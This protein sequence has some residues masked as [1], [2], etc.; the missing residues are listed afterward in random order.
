MLAP[1]PMPCQI[2]RLLEAP[3][4]MMVAATC[5]TPSLPTIGSFC[6]PSNSTGTLRFF[7]SS[8]ADP[9]GGRPVQGVAARVDELT[10]CLA[11]A[12][13]LVDQVVHLVRVAGARRG[14]RFG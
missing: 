6:T 9:L 5:A 3:A 2:T 11:E 10:V 4:L 14:H 8:F 13:G 12:V 1:C 7:G